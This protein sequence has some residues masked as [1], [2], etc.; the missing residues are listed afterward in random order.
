VREVY[1]CPGPHGGRGKFIPN[2]GSI[3]QKY[4]DEEIESW[5]DRLYMDR[6]KTV[7]HDVAGGSSRLMRDANDAR[8]VGKK[9][10][11]YRDRL[12]R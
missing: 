9:I 8:D 3:W 11:R 6:V 4:S 10:L 7:H 12:S 5:L 2:G 1:A